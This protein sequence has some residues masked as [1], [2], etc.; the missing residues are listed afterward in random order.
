MVK[1]Q[2][3][4]EFMVVLAIYLV[5]LSALI[6]GLAP[7]PGRFSES[8][9]SFKLSLKAQHLATIY[10]VKQLNNEFTAYALTESG[11]LITEQLVVCESGD[12]KGSAKVYVP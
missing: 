10:S 4:L 5:L 3:S 11:C 9:E 8:G 2:L 1:A 6:S 7:L 12:A